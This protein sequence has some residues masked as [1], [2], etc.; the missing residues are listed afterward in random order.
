MIVSLLNGLVG[1]EDWSVCRRSGLPAAARPGDDGRHHAESRHR[2]AV[3]VLVPLALQRAG[4]TRHGINV[5]LTFVTDSMG[6]FLFW[7]WLVCF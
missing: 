4:A 2:A 3:G 7:G 5:L 1:S 6:F